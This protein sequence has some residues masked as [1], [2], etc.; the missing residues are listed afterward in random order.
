[1]KSS[2]LALELAINPH[3]LKIPIDS[4]WVL[5]YGYEIRNL[6][7]LKNLLEYN[8]L[9]F[10][11]LTQSHYSSEFRPIF[12]IDRNCK[13]LLSDSCFLKVLSR[14]RNNLLILCVVGYCTGQR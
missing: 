2:K 14:E 10:E 1:M 8:V 13:F 9:I 4:T 7:T 11:H 5:S 3:I 6:Q 12:C